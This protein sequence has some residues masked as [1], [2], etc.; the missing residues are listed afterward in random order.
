MERM[1]FDEFAACRVDKVC[2]FFD[3]LNI[4]HVDNVL[5]MVVERAVESDNVCCFEEFF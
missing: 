5:C 3:V 4:A 2:S 1:G